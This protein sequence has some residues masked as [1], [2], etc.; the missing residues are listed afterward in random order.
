MEGRHKINTKWE[1]RTIA[2]R[3]KNRSGKTIENY[4]YS[5]TGQKIREANKEAFVREV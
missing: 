3:G 1:W 2:E 5:S 4:K